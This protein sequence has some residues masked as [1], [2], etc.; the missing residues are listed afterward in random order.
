MRIL[1]VAF[2]E[3]IT[4]ARWMDQ[5]SG[6][7]WDIHL[8]PSIRRHNHAPELHDLTLHDVGLWRPERLDASV[9]IAG[10]WPGAR[11]AYTVQ[12]WLER[13][14]TWRRDR[15]RF[16]AATIRRLKP[17]LVHTLEM[18]HAAYLML[19]ACRYLGPRRP[20]WIYSSWGSDINYFQHQPEHAARI[21][22]VL[23]EC[24]GLF[25]DCDRDRRLAIEYGFTGKYLGV[26]P[27][28]GGYDLDEMR[29]CRQPGPASARRVIAVK[30][31]QSERYGGRALLALQA[32]HRCADALK[33]Y[34]VVVYS[35][36]T[37]SVSDVVRHI[38]ATSPIRIEVLP[39]VPHGEVLSLLGQSRIHLA[40]S[41]TDGT[42][43][44]M[45][46]A[47]IMGA[48]PV[49][50]DTVSTGEWIENGINGALVPSDLPEAIE[51]ALRRALAEDAWVDQAAAHNVA[52]ADERLGRGAIAR[53]VV[54]SYEGC[55]KRS[56]SRTRHPTNSQSQAGGRI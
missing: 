45:L 32:I 25:T 8:F 34:R 18:Q 4:T 55:L 43:N 48:L 15:A 37:E 6:E 36:Q 40:I 33:N 38:A 10:A 9:R 39:R 35:A 29:R 11:G 54:E 26:Y 12:R 5:L 44:A 14:T 51:A 17:D 30:G 13:H 47:I 22:S 27:G 1:F 24:D 3:N 28:G 2:S 31:Y 49:Q 20:P 21:R 7:G 53:D 16:L 23:R 41:E 19:D 42:P 56:R 52:L 50:T 46:E